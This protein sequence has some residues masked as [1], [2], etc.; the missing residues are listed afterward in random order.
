VESRDGILFATAA[1]RVSLSDA[2]SVFTKACDVS[3]ER[4]YRILVDCLSVEGELSDMER[5]ELGRTMAEYCNSRSLTPRVATFGYPP[6]IN[7]FAAQVA[8]NRGLVADTF[9]ELQIAMDWLKRFGPKA[10]CA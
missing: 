9:S 4:V 6:L 2:I 3:E 8:W 10:A 1:G 7:G 5:Y